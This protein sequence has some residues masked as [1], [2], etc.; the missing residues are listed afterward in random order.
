MGGQYEVGKINGAD[1]QEYQRSYLLMRSLTPLLKF[2]TAKQ[3]VAVCSEAMETF[4][5]SGYMEDSE[6]P[7]LLRDAQVL[8]V[9][10]GTTNIM[11]LDVLRVLAKTKGAAFSTFISHGREIMLRCRTTILDAACK[12]LAQRLDALADYGRDLLSQMDEEPLAAQAF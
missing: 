10:E 4:G 12:L 11:S 2:Y 6:M 8:P 7:V 3:A 5:G 1:S 9:W